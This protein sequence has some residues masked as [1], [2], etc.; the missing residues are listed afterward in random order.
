MEHLFGEA[1]GNFQWFAIGCCGAGNATAGEV[2]DF[3]LAVG[4]RERVID[5]RDVIFAF[6]ADAES[7]TR[8]EVGREVCAEALEVG[9]VEEAE[10][11][12]CCGVVVLAIFVPSGLEGVV[13]FITLG[14]GLVLAPEVVRTFEG[15]FS[16]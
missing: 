8:Y 2:E 3:L 5:A 14:E 15:W 6:E 13:G 7:R 11:Y 4:V 12:I 10:G 1:T 9:A 16:R